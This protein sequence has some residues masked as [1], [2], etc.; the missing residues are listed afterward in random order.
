MTQQEIYQRNK[1]TVNK[2]RREEELGHIACR[3][4]KSLVK[5]YA[6]AIGSTGSSSATSS[7]IRSM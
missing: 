1:K 7:G 2:I 5:R 4:A 6:Q 3:A